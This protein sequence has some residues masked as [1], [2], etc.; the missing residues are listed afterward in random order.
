MHVRAPSLSLASALVAVAVSACAQPD[1]EPPTFDPQDATAVRDNLAAYMSADPTNE[2]DAFFSQFTEDIH[3]IYNDQEPWVGIDGLR[4]RDWCG[5]L[6][7]D[8]SAGRVEGSGYL[9]Y[10]RGTYRLSLDCGDDNPV[11]SEGVFLSAHRRQQDG[12]WRIESL[13]QVARTS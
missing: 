4:N 1:A 12:S 9:A 13:L 6:S 5:T 3:W 8:I 11:N 10:A 7:A 2:P